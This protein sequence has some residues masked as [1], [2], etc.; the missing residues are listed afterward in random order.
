MINY[1]FLT[2]SKLEKA[3]NY[4][5]KSAY[6][7]VIAGG[8]DILVDI[9]NKS[10]RLPEISH[11]LDISHIATLNFIQQVDHHIEIGPLVTHSGLIHESLIKNNFPVLVEAA[12]TIG[13]T[14]IRNRGTIGGNICNASPARRFI[15]PFNSFKSRIDFNR[16]KS[17]KE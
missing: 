2:T 17:K 6:V 16:E 12:N 10:K 8:T 13:S 11:L 15:T 5:D 4:L 1:D 9:H 14:Q 3:L 7:K